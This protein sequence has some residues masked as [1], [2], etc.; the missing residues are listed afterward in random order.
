MN[1]RGKPLPPA[2]MT[3]PTALVWWNATKGGVDEFSRAMNCLARNNLS[4]NP[5]VSA[6][7]R[8]ICGKVN[9]VGV[10][11]RPAVAREKGKLHRRTQEYDVQHKG[12]IRMRH[13]VSSC[14]T[15]RSFARNLARE[16]NKTYGVANDE[17]RTADCSGNKRR[18]EHDEDELRP[19]FSKKVVENYSK[20]GAKRRR[21][22][23]RMEH[24]KVSGRKTY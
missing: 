21:L 11:H 13:L 12:Y 9:N 18:R 20:A 19:F 4:E 8:N 2:R 14:E 24:K 16:Y 6:L 3:R 5:L 7:A 10:V 23:S 15:F 17:L 22:G 1:N